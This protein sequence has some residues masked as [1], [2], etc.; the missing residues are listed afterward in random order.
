MPNSDNPAYEFCAQCGTDVPQD[1]AIIDGG[2]PFCSTDCHEEW[3]ADEEEA[4]DDN[5]D[6]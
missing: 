4:E 5:D 2:Y 6:E 3:Q 1:Q